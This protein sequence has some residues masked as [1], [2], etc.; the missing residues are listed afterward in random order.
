MFSAVMFSTVSSFGTGVFIKCVANAMLKQR[1]F[2]RPWN[3]LLAGSAFG[4]IG[5]NYYR[6]EEELIT[7]V[8]DKREERGMPR[9]SRESVFPQIRS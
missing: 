3:H 6:W 9:I 4:Y 8:N 7:L 5:Y 1:Y 2:A